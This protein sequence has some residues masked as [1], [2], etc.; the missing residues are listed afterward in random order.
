MNPE[1]PPRLKI[2]WHFVFA[3]FSFMNKPMSAKKQTAASFQKS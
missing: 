1:S 2:Q 3:W